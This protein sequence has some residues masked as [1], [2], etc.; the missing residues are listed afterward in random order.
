[1]WDRAPAE[2]A[3]PRRKSLPRDLWRWKGASRALPI[4][5]CLLG[6]IRGPDALPR[7]NRSPW[8][9][10]SRLMGS[11]YWVHRHGVPAT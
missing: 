5:Q 9:D 11:S 2:A 1:M 8:N 7:P 6:S 10:K 4:F 3:L